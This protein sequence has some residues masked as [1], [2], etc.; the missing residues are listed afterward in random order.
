LYLASRHPQHRPDQPLPNFPWIA[1]KTPV[2]KAHRT[3]LGTA[4]L[5][6][7]PRVPASKANAAPTSSSFRRRLRRRFQRAPSFR[8]MASAPYDMDSK[9]TSYMVRSYIWYRASQLHHV[10]RARE[11][12]GK[13]SHS[14]RPCAPHAPRVSEIVIPPCNLPLRTSISLAP[15]AGDQPTTNARHR[16]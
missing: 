7:V 15:A 1:V 13:P 4:D 16:N 2:A 3:A 10:R 6:Y 14:R 12:H 9:P 5:R 11:R 8:F